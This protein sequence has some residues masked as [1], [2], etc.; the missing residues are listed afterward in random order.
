[1]Q[2]DEG[3]FQRLSSPLGVIVREAEAIQYGI[4]SDDD[5]RKISVV[6]V[7][8]SETRDAL[9]RPLPGGLYDPKMGPT[10]HYSSCPTCGLDYSLCPGHLGRV[11]LGLPVYMPTLFPQLVMLLRGK[12]LHCHQFRVDRSKLWPFVDALAL[13]DAGL[14]V[15]AA[16]VLP[17]ECC[18]R[19][20]DPAVGPSAEADPD[21][22]AEAE[23]EAASEDGSEDGSA[24]ADARAHAGYLSVISADGRAVLQRARAAARD[25]A[26]PAASRRPAARSQHLISLRKKASDPLPSPPL[27]SALLPPPP[28][29][30]PCSLTPV[31]A[32]PSTR[33]GPSHSPSHRL[34]HTPNATHPDTDGPR[35]VRGLQGRQQVLALPALLA[36]HQGRGRRQA[37]RRHALAEEPDGQRGPRLPPG[38][39]RRERR[40]RAVRLPPNRRQ[41]RRHRHQH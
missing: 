35:P 27:P 6:E 28:I 15:D 12:C 18:D 40:R 41:A 3:V 14:L 23:A 39:R 26:P 21:L 20:V 8:S 13:I 5:I 10:D 33:P 24:E 2:H 34:P 11:E 7:N 22:H 1:M 17:Q 36:H 30:T 4:Y 29:A 31:L 38:E 16:K 37:I 9:S 32:S 25:D 19:V